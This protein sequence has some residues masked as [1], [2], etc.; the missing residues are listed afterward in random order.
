MKA[1][2]RRVFLKAVGIVGASFA[3]ELAWSQV[4]PFGYMKSSGFV[5]SNPAPAGLPPA[6]GCEPVGFASIGG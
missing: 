6:I 3:S 4:I 1:L 5:Y 2:S